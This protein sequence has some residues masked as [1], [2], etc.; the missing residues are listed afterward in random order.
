MTLCRS[1][2][3]PLAV[4]QPTGVRFTSERYVLAQRSSFFLYKTSPKKRSFHLFSLFCNMGTTDA[5]EW[6]TLIDPLLEKL[7]RDNRPLFEAA[8]E[9]IVESESR[10]SFPLAFLHVIKYHDNE[11]RRGQLSKSRFIS[12]Y[13]NWLWFT[14]TKELLGHARYR[15]QYDLINLSVSVLYRF[16]RRGCTEISTTMLNDL[17]WDDFAFALTSQ[18][19]PPNECTISYMSPG[20]KFE[21]TIRDGCDDPATRKGWMEVDF[22]SVLLPGQTDFI[23]GSTFLMPKTLFLQLRKDLS[24][25]ERENLNQ[26]VRPL[27]KDRHYIKDSLVV[28]EIWAYVLPVKPGHIIDCRV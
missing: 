12:W 20:V 27:V 18:K 15:F 22:P 5:P 3:G 25:N 28:T 24:A 16:M 21:A 1:V 6:F 17:P 19:P 11:I 14:T 8:Y 23:F 13:W 9:V 7:H 10:L 2:V 4:A 26:L